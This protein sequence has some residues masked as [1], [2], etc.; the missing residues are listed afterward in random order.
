[1]V[2]AVAGPLGARSAI[3]GAGRVGAGVASAVASPGPRDEHGNLSASLS[4]RPAMSSGPAGPRPAEVFRSFVSELAA[5]AHGPDLLDRLRQGHEPDPHGWCSHPAH[6]H[7]WE[8]YPCA[9]VR[10]ANLVEGADP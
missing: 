10:L 7:R 1:M 3:G 6:A 9:M 5:F 8:R 2:V 4:G